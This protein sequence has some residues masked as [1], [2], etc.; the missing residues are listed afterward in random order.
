M[1]FYLFIKVSFYILFT[2]P[3]QKRAREKL[4]Y[5]ES[6]RKWWYKNDIIFYLIN[7]FLLTNEIRKRFYLNEVRLKMQNKTLRFL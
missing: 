6:Q 3:S 7:C 1:L 5:I 4:N 2:Y